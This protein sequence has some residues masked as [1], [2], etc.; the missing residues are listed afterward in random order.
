[1]TQIEKA[2]EAE[3]LAL[4]IT[5]Y[6]DKKTRKQD[7]LNQPQ[8]SA[9]GVVKKPIQNQ[10]AKNPSSGSFS[11]SASLSFSISN[12]DSV[13]NSASASNSAS[14]S[15]E[16]FTVHTSSLAS[17]SALAVQDSSFSSASVSNLALVLE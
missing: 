15:N 14:V 10:G 9:N 6:S 2:I 5:N 11:T 12:S 3:D 1:V 16:T 8:K 17:L 13:S 7:A 4:K